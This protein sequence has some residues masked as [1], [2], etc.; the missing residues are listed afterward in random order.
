MSIST[1][2]SQQ[3]LTLIEL[4][5]AAALSTLVFI[6]IMNSFLAFFRNRQRSA[7]QSALQKIYAN[8]ITDITNNS[9]WAHEV[10]VN[11]NT[12]TIVVYIPDTSDTITYQ[13]SDPKTLTKTS[14][15]SGVSTSANLIPPEV[16]IT[17][18]KLTVMPAAP[19]FSGFFTITLS[20]E[21]TID[22]S[23]EYTGSSTISVR[24]SEIGEP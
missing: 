23:K 10:L 13:Y 2:R 7:S 15:I 3:G 14:K 24:M 19:N 6:L 21:S 22:T 20:L 4:L 12:N 9:R 11:K 5:L 8:I 18:F 1:P 17:N 16:N